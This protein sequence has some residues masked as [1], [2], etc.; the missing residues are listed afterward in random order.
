MNIL[1]TAACSV[2]SNN[3]LYNLCMNS[4]YAPY[5]ILI[6]TVLAGCVLARVCSSANRTLPS[7]HGSAPPPLAGRVARREDL[8]GSTGVVATKAARKSPSHKEAEP[9]PRV[10]PSEVPSASAKREKAQLAEE[11]KKHLLAAGRSIEPKKLP[12]YS[13]SNELLSLGYLKEFGGIWRHHFATLAHKYRLDIPEKEMEPIISSSKQFNAALELLVDFY[14][15][16]DD[17]ETALQYGLLALS[18]ENRSILFKLANPL[19][20][21]NLLEKAEETLEKMRVD[22][23]RAELAT[24]LG[25]KYLA[26]VPPQMENAKKLLRKLNASKAVDLAK[27]IADKYIEANQ[28]DKAL[29]VVEKFISRLGGK[30]ESYFAKIADKYIEANQLDKAL[31]VVEKFISRLGG[32]KESYFAKIADKYIEANQLDKALEVVEKFFPSFGGKKEPYFRKIAE[33]YTSVGDHVK[34]EKVTKMMG[35]R[36]QLKMGL[37]PF[38]L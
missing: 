25:R 15:G 3:T 10:E 5:V 14:L 30:K 36:F 11:V 13:N 20:E 2:F 8:S 19:I 16:K 34:A 37:D 24:K 4:T 38:S 26:L 33:M 12:P 27:S 21:S 18:F 9:T 7:Q 35:S 6:G 29:E 28:L 31:E 1:P 17:F 22:E 32:E 23:G